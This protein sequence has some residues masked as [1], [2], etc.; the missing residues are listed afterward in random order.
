MTLPVFR[1]GNEL[2]R[3]QQAIVSTR[4]QPCIAALKHLHTQLTA[5]QIGL[6]NAGNFQFAALTGCDGLGNIDHLVVIKIQ[7]SY[8]KVAFR[9]RG[10]FLNAA[11]SAFNIK[12]NNAIT[13]GAVHV[14]SEHNRAASL[15]VCIRKHLGKA[16]SIKKFYRPIPAHWGSC[17]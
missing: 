14:I 2:T 16:V 13:L 3:F 7:A 12:R 5:S 6:V 10:F 9:L 11:G 4:I 17:R 8:R 15:P 1:C